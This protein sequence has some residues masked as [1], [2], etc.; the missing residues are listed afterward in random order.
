V[1]WL[2]GNR[3]AGRYGSCAEASV[4]DEGISARD[5]DELAACF[6]VHARELFGYACVIARGD[7]AQADEPASLVEVAP[8][9]GICLR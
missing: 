7:R 9:V 8:A 6:A 2:L 3:L 5:A 1:V 4:G